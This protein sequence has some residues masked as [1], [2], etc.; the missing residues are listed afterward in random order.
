MNWR[1]PRRSPTRSATD[2]RQ[3]QAFACD[4]TDRASVTARGRGDAKQSL[5]PIDVLVNNAGWDVFKP[6]IKTE[7]A[8]GTS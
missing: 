2:G 5:G 3:A 4:I 8:S 6:F 7:P 1:P